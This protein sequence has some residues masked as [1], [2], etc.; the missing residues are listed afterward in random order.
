MLLLNP[1]KFSE[2]DSRHTFTMHVPVFVYFP[3]QSVS[4]ID[5][6]GLTK[7]NDVDFYYRTTSATLGDVLDARLDPSA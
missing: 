2:F 6:R 1:F 7:D 4:S 5:S 3:V